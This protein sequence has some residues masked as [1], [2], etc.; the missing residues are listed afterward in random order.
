MFH[1]SDPSFIVA[2][3]ITYSIENKNVNLGSTGAKSEAEAEGDHAGHNYDYVDKDHS[4][5]KEVNNYSYTLC[6]FQT[7]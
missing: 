6:M 2:G 3:N 7:L 5:F 4:K 1:I